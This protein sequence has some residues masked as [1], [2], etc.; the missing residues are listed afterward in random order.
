LGNRC[1]KTL[2]REGVD[3]RVDRRTLRD[4]SVDRLATIHVGP[5]R[6][7]SEI[8]AQRE[9]ITAEIGAANARLAEARE[10]EKLAEDAIAAVQQ[11][12]AELR[13]LKLAREQ[14]REEDKRRRR[15]LERAGESS[16]AP[17]QIASRGSGSR[18]VRSGSSF[19]SSCSLKRMQRISR[20]LTSRVL[21][22]QPRWQAR[23]RRR[24]RFGA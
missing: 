4:Q 8:R 10:A 13:A 14:Q 2:K 1:N 17:P 5:E 16:S 7:R 20:A 22:H 3:E 24:A 6:G 15:E 21:A 19:A 11:I 18:I 12:E 9:Q 23:R